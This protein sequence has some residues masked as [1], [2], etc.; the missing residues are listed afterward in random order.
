MPQSSIDKGLNRSTGSPTR[1]EAVLRDLAGG[2][3]LCDAAVQSDIRAAEAIDRLLGIADEKQLSRSGSGGA[4][5]ALIGIGRTQQ[6]QD[7]G[8][9][10]VGVL[11]FIDQDPVI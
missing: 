7:L 3:V 9:Q 11:E 10:R 6:E 4:P 8:L 2:Q 1:L 5:V